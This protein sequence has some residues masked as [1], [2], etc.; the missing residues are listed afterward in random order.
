[1]LSSNPL[2]NTRAI[3]NKIA[4]MCKTLIVIFGNF[5]SFSENLI[6][7]HLNTSFNNIFLYDLFSLYSFIIFSYSCVLSLSKSIPTFFLKFS[8]PHIFEL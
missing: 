2:V 8:V 6:V 7:K 1:M 3:L 4:F 5:F